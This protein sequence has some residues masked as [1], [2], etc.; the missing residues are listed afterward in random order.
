[1]DEKTAVLIEKTTK[2]LRRNTKQMPLNEIIEGLVEVVT[3]TKEYNE[4]Y[5]NELRD[6]RKVIEEYKSAV[7]E[8]NESIVK[9]NKLLQEEMER[10]E[11]LEKALK[12]YATKDYYEPFDEVDKGRSDAF[13]AIDLDGGGT[14]R[15]AL[16]KG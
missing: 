6:R 15:E 16:N 4:I 3:V 7:I 13:N 9:A 10:V 8:K 5:L 2:L 1:M 11:E 14:A 12:F